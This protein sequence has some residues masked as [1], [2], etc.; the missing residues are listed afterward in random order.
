MKLN[1]IVVW[2]FEP[3]HSE[4]IAPERLTDDF[5]GEV[6]NAQHEQRSIDEKDES[7]ARFQY[8]GRLRNPAYGSLQML[9]PYSEVTRSKDSLRKGSASAPYITSGKVSPCSD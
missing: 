8:A 1:G 2:P 6:R 3:V 5:V 7:T 4:V 9:A